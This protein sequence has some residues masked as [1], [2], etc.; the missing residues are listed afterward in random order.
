M[1]NSNDAI[2]Q[3]YVGEIT[4]IIQTVILFSNSMKLV[5]NDNGNRPARHQLLFLTKV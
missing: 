3:F 4:L 5:L 2:S 1:L